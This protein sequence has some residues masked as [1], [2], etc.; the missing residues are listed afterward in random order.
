M[1]MLRD[2]LKELRALYGPEL[3]SDH[4]HTTFMLGVFAVLTEWQKHVGTPLPK[5]FVSLRAE[6]TSLYNELRSTIDRL[7]EKA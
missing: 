5:E 1:T 6:A 4:I 3:F 2:H 7:K